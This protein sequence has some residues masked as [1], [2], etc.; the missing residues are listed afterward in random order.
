MNERI[1]MDPKHFARLGKPYMRALKVSDLPRVS[2]SVV[3]ESGE[4]DVLFEVLLSDR[5]LPVIQGRVSG[6]LN[7][8]CQS[9]LDIFR[10]PLEVEMNLMCVYNESQMQGVLEHLEPILLNEDGRLD[11]L[12]M[13]EQEILLNLPIVPRKDCTSDVNQAYYVLPAQ[14]QETEK[15]QKIQTQK[16]NVKKD[17]PFAILASLKIKKV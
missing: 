1:M 6:W 7:L 13:I 4:I 12:D 8:E 3:D 9:S 16:L 2:E 14:S 15:T 11:V 5:S 17:N 10:Y